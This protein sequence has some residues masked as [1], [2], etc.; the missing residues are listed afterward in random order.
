MKLFS[1]FIA[2]VQARFIDE[3]GMP[4]T[5]GDETLQDQFNW[6]LWRDCCEYTTCGNMLCCA[7]YC[8]DNGN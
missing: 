5:E 6:Q 3:A 2:L 8:D 4:L 1:L 7:R